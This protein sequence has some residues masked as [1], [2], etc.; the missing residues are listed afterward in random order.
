[1]IVDDVAYF[2]E[3]FFQDGPVAVAIDEVVGRRRHLLLTPPATTTCSTPAETKSPPGKRP[4]SATRRAARR[5][6]KRSPAKPD[7]CLD[8]NPAAGDQD[9]TFGI[10]VE[11]EEELTLDLQWA[12]PWYGVKTDLDAYL[13]DSA[14]NV[15]VLEEGSANSIAEGKPVEV[16]GWENTTAAPQEVR[17]AIDRCFSTEEEAKE[18]KGCNPFADASA[19]PAAQGDPARER[20]RGRAPPSTP[21]RTDDDVV[22]PSVYGHAGTASAIAVGAVPFDDSAEAEPYT[23][24]GPV[25]H[26]FGPVRTRRRRRRSARR[27]RSPSPTSP[28]P[29]AAGPRSSCPAGEPGIFRFCGTSAAAPHAAAVAALIQQANPSA[30]RLP[31]RRRSR[32]DRSPRRS[33]RPRRRRRR[34]DRRP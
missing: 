23:S 9:K 34:P 21:N 32:R 22:G 12:E 20:L 13:L 30:S 1:M 16:I 27:R 7:H 17:L 24:R 28:P 2:E 4:N 15:L 14:G 25:T 29:I 10:T 19:K 8:F 3:P 31:D 6:W 33:L 18:E 26:Y 5:R 11:P